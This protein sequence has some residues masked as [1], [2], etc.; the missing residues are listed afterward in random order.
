MSL[1]SQALRH[2]RH[3][4]KVSGWLALAVGA[5]SLLG[6]ATRNEQ[7]KTAF[8]GISLKANAAIAMCLLASTLLLWVPE[9]RS[10]WAK[11]YGRIA[12][13]LATTIGALTLGQ[14]VFSF[15]LGIDQLLFV[16]PAGEVATMSPGRMGPPA[17]I[18]FVILGLGFCFFERHTTRRQS[19]GQWFAL[20]GCPLPLLA[21][22]GFVTR[23]TQLYGIARYTGIAPHTAFAILMLAL[24]LFFA[25][26]E[27]E[28]ASIFV[29]DNP[30]G[31]VARTMLPVAIVLPLGLGWLREMGQRLHFFDVAF[32][33]AALLLA[34]MV[35]FAVMVWRVARRLSTLA[36][37]RQLA[38]LAS[39]RARAEAQRLA[40]TNLQT[41]NVLEALL[42]H[43]PVGLVFFNRDRN[44]IRINEFLLQN[45]P[46][47]KR[48]IPQRS[49][50]DLLDGAHPALEGAINRAFEFG[51]STINVEL[52]IAF[53][54]DDDRSWLAGVFPVR[55]DAPQPS[56]CGA[57]LMEITER[58]R[59][60]AQR[61]TLLDSERAARVE[62]ERAA[63]L[64]DQFLA[65]LSHE[66]RTPLNAIL[67][68]ARL[69]RQS[70]GKFP[71]VERPVEVIERNARIPGQTH[72]RP[73]GRVANRQ[74]EDADCERAG[75]AE[76]RGSCSTHGSS[77]QCRIEAREHRREIWTKN[78]LK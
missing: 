11:M 15:D 40:A 61:A 41:L 9:T 64:K 57:V 42:A 22:V 33:R 73:P 19:V 26:A 58:K 62:A 51:V 60:E 59:L 27:W 77:A 21:L 65:T 38:E 53:D 2:S 8:T 23:S 24:G 30:G 17:S 55:D 5:A 76:N 75:L 72:R 44:C 66:L 16:E 37:A 71:E 45:L 29:V 69:L 78:C 4:A 36:N 12:S 13:I 39:Y 68:W 47:K 14:H 6:W 70:V 1:N 54:A 49:V 74:R 20:A 63:L 48:D 43:A 7:L 3:V 67:G 34:L 50:S 56:I 18:S 28:P 10:N 25:R 46:P 31:E 32:G 35:V 52:N